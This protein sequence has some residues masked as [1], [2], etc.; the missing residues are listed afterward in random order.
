MS[1]A[2]FTATFVGSIAAPSVAI[3]A[4]SLAGESSITVEAAGLYTLTGRGGPPR[5]ELL[6][7][8]D[9]N[10]DQIGVVS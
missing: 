2:R 8:R 10:G 5:R 4:V 9:L 6:W 7:V 3:P 1:S